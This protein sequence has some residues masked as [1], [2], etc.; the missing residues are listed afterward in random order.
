MCGS[1]GLWPQHSLLQDVNVGQPL[2]AITQHP[3]R[4]IKYWSPQTSFPTLP[5]AQRPAEHKVVL[6]L[7][8]PVSPEGFQVTCEVAKQF[9]GLISSPTN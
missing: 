2:L 7:L 6:A 9:L 5:S 8:T 3:L 4:V 1:L